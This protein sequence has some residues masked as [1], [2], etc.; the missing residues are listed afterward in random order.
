MGGKLGFQ[1]QPIVGKGI[2]EHITP[3]KYEDI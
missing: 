2:D 1:S 3:I